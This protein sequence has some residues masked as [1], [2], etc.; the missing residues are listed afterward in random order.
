L[1]VKN[2]DVFVSKS[3]CIRLSRVPKWGFCTHFSFFAYP[4][5]RNCGVCPND[6]GDGVVF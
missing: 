4:Y 5:S 6:I 2:L 3:H 1:T